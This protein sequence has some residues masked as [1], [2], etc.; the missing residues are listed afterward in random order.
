MAVPDYSKYFLKGSGSFAC[1]Y[2]SLNPADPLV[3]IKSKNTAEGNKKIVSNLGL[4]DINNETKYL[5]YP[6]GEIED[7][8]PALPRKQC[9]LK[10]TPEK[11]L[12]IVKIPNG[13]KDL[14]NLQLPSGDIYIFFTG[15]M[16]ILEGILLLHSRKIAHLD[17][18]PL[19]M[20]G[21][22][23]PDGTY[24]LRIIDF[25]YSKKTDIPSDNSEFYNKGVPFNYPYWSYDLR[26]LNDDLFIEIFEGDLQEDT[27]EFKDVFIDAKYPDYLLRT[28]DTDLVN[29]I[30][31]TITDS[32][33]S[34]VLLKSDVFSLGLSLY[35]IWKRLTG[36]G[37]DS[38]G[39][40][41]YGLQD[42]I[43]S[44]MYPEQARDFIK[45]HYGALPAGWGMKESRTTGKIFFYNITNNLAFWDIKKIK[46]CGAEIEASN[47]VFELVKRMCDPN[48]FTRLNLEAAKQAYITTVLPAIQTAYSTVP[49]VGNGARAN[50]NADLG[51]GSRSRRKNTKRNYLKAKKTR[52]KPKR[53]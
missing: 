33:K 34:E 19:N 39:V 26:I 32:N 5:L 27:D 40:L 30:F 4:P 8:P 37:L 15:F 49:N 22:K 24:N 31:T 36:Y 9:T 28:L 44:A 29:E 10:N 21:K 35:L 2:G 6:I 20:V 52:A 46:T 18:K 13:G 50:A 42:E 48:P 1:T 3:Q 7:V 23:E 38:E 45:I 53:K 47:K 43:N 14:E 17:I 12:K 25:G 11:P 51:G 41:T 16:N